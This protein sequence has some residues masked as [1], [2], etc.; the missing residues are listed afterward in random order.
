MLQSRH[1]TV[2]WDTQ[3]IRC[4]LDRHTDEEGVDDLDDADDSDS[5]TVHQENPTTHSVNVSQSTLIE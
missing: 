5:N 4:E 1:Q 2:S 3:A